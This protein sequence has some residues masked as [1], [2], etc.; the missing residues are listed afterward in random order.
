MY[1]AEKTECCVVA[2]LNMPTEYIHVLGNKQYRLVK[3]L[4][5]AT[6]IADRETAKDLINYYRSSTV[7]NQEL[8]IVPM[9]VTYRLIDERI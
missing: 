7:D 9:E 8:V 4:S 6:K 2:T 1:Y 5:G 3:R